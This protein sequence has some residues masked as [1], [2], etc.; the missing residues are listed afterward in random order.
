MLAA[1]VVGT[2]LFVKVDHTP[3]CFTAVSA[4]GNGGKSAAGTT[5]LSNL[6]KDSAPM[7]CR[8]SS[9]VAIGVLSLHAW[10]YRRHAKTTHGRR[11]RP[12]SS[13]ANSILA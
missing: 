5:D 4:V 6:A 1:A 12:E 8:C 3:A 10:A 7:V 9:T 2:Y 13:V 11:G